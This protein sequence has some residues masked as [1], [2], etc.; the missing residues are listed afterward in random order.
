MSPRALPRV[1]MAVR[2]VH[3]GHTEDAVLEEVLDGGRTL[4]AG[5]RRFTLRPLTGEHVAE[6]E[7][8]YGLRL[9]LDPR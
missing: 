1:G 7:P 3:L 5:G 9:V 6:G 8:Y 4:V 2:L